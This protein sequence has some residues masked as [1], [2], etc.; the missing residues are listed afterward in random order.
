ME[1][2]SRLIAD[3]R[4]SLCA[5]LTGLAVFFA[6]ATLSESPATTQVEVA[7]RDLPSGHRL[8]A[9]DIRVIEVPEEAAVEH[10][11]EEI[12]GRQVAGRM[13]AGEPFTDHRVIDPRSLPEGMVLASVVVE[14][15]VAAL[16]RPGDRV[17]V[18]A[19]ADGTDEEELTL[20]TAASVVLIEEADAGTA[21]GVEAAPEAAAA[22][23]RATLVGRLTLVHSLG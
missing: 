13:R 2:L 1:R 8:T 5:V 7:A 20:A 12:A 23:A 3:H 10:R 18:L 19:I 16:V 11:P 6:L 9:D 21:V 15:E 14:P 4:R 17:D 22:I